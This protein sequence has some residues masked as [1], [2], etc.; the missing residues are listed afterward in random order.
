MRPI[1][2][3]TFIDC[4]IKTVTK[5][6][7]TR[8]TGTRKLLIS[9]MGVGEPLLNLSLIENIYQRENKIKETLGYNEISY[10]LATM[11]PMS[12]D[13]LLIM[14][15]RTKIPLKVHFSLHSPLDDI[16]SK[17]IPASSLS[18]EQA[19]EELRKYAMQLRND[20]D[21]MAVF[22]QVHTTCQPVEIHYTLI[23]GVNDSDE[24]LSALTSLFANSPMNIPIKFIAFNPKDDM[25]RSPREKEWIEHLREARADAR[26]RTYCPPGGEIGSSC[27]EFTKHYYHEEIETPEQ[28]AAFEQWKTEHEVF[29]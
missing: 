3:D 8:I 27:G 2:A 5:A 20:S 22:S 14:Q 17:L 23:D 18:V 13:D 11:M 6:D 24:E 25:C 16:R 7:G 1:S 12:L 19:V 28:L 4:L 10:A 9:F 26:V 15:A 29:I 21:S